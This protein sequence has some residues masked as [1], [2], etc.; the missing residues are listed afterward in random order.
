MHQL[1]G[2]NILIVDNDP[3][4]SSDLRMKLARNGASV[5]VISSFKA[6][7]LMVKRNRIDVAFVPF[8]HN[9]QSGDLRAILAARGIPQ[10][11]TGSPPAQFPRRS[12]ER[13][14]FLALQ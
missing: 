6:A 1:S 11:I 10:I 9:D 12:V 8:E 5:R 13:E 4:S 7:L 3:P 2:V 14:V